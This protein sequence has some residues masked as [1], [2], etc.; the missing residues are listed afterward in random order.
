[1]TDK[2]RKIL[3]KGHKYNTADLAY[4]HFGFDDSIEY[5]ALVVAPAY[6]PAKLIQDSSFKITKLGSLSFCEGVP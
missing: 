2:I 3:D 6:T 4:I 1:M 5:D